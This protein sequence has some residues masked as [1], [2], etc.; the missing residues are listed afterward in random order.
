VPQIKIN[1][2]VE[3]E[4]KKN[5]LSPMFGKPVASLKKKDRKEIGAKSHHEF[6]IFNQENKNP[7][8]KKVEVREFTKEEVFYC[9]EIDLMF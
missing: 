5:T 7:L 6:L 3:E 2:Q 9:F 8:G 1:N 4:E